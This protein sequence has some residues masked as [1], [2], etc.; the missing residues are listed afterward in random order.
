MNFW[1]SI[2]SRMLDFFRDEKFS[3]GLIFAIT[4]SGSH[5]KQFFPHKKDDINE[6]PDDIS[7]GSR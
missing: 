5:L 7:F 6:L 1:D 3:E 2:K 4:E